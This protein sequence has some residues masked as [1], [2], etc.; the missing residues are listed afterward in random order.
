MTIDC[1]IREENHSVVYAMG[2]SNAE[3]VNVW[4]DELYGKSI[5]YFSA[6]I[7]QLQEKS[8]KDFILLFSLIRFTE[9]PTRS[10]LYKRDRYFSTYFESID[11]I[12]MIKRTDWEW[13]YYFIIPKEELI[14][15]CF[16]ENDIPF[17]QKESAIILIDQSNVDY[18]HIC[19]I[20][21]LL[22]QGLNN[23]AKPLIND[24]YVAITYHS[25]GVDGHSINVHHGKNWPPIIA[26]M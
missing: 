22:E 7:H 11:S 23:K 6:I 13:F 16:Y 25:V 12:K 14:P 5:E 9:A 10:R 20:E 26:S 18:T 21:R 3:E 1:Q 2:P 24:D 17:A 4:Y 19:S 15:S 8:Q